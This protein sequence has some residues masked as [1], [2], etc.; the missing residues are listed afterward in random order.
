MAIHSRASFSLLVNNTNTTWN[1]FSYLRILCKNWWGPTLSTSRHWTLYSKII[2]R[3]LSP[4]SRED[5]LNHGDR[6]HVGNLLRAHP[7]V[8]HWSGSGKI[9]GQS[10]QRDSRPRSGHLLLVEFLAVVAQVV[11]HRTLEQEVPGLIPDVSWTFSLFLLSSLSRLS[12]SG[13]SLIRMR[14]NTTKSSKFP[15][16][17]K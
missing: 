17:K 6:H 4:S 13:K 12:I 15:K 1:T 16:R 7:E 14:Y 2:L 9:L 5:S 11:T 8:R 3:L 10:E